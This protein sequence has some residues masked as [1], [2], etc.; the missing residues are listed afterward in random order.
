MTLGKVDP[1]G[2]DALLDRFVEVVEPELV[3]ATIGCDDDAEFEA[4]VVGKGG[5]E[6]RGCGRNS[7]FLEELSSALPF[8]SGLSRSSS[9]EKT[10]ACGAELI[11][12]SQWSAVG[13]EKERSVLRASGG[14]GVYWWPGWWPECLPSAA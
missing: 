1:L 14:A 13:F 6:E 11:G 4:R 12:V 5:C 10:G 9:G 7:A 8:R 3:D 2:E